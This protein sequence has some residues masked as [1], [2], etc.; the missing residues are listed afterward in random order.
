MKKILLFS[1][2]ALI[3]IGLQAHGACLIENL[4]LKK[5]AVC[6]GA[7]PVKKSQQILNPNQTDSKQDLREMYQIPTM[8]TPATTKDGFPML[9]QN[10]MFGACFPK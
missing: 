10:C 1:V 9:N 3:T 2:L 8:S 6:G 5:D 7:A 4:K